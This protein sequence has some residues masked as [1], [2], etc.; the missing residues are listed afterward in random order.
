DC[1]DS[2]YAACWTRGNE[3]E[4]GDIFVYLRRSD[5]DTK[6][7]TSVP[8][9]VHSKNVWLSAPIPNPSS[10]RE[11]EI[12]YFIP[13]DCSVRFEIFSTNG[14]RVKVLS[15]ITEA[16]GTHS[17][18]FSLSGLSAGSYILRMSTAYGEFERKIVVL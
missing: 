9:V 7:Q 2:V 12:S 8:V 15:D 11:V 1:Y 13:G 18:S 10:G 16:R 14:E 17:T 6:G 3:F 4:D 5:E